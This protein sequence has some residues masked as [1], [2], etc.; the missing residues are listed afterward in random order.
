MFT[1]QDV[2]RRILH[3]FGIWPNEDQVAQQVPAE[4]REVICS[5]SRTR[6]T[7]LI[8]SPSSG[9][10]ISSSCSSARANTQT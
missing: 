1:Q 9:S 3:A 10:A 5:T 8:S 7:G 6:S 4:S 2:I